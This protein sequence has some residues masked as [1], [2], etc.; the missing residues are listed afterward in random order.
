MK[1]MEDEETI[2]SVTLWCSSIEDVT[3]SIHKVSEE[4]V[5]EVTLADVDIVDLIND[6]GF[7]NLLAHIKEEDIMEYLESKNKVEE[8]LDA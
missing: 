5:L 7:E 1:Y 8:G 3:P 6:I 4:A 2:E